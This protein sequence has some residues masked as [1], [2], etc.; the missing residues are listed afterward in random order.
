MEPIRKTVALT[1]TQNCNLACTYCYE[2]YKSKQEMPYELAVD[3]IDQYLNSSS[4]SYDECV[5]DF[6]GGEPFLNFPLIKRICEYVWSRKWKKPYLFS[7]TTNGTMIHGEIQDWLY[8]NSRRFHVGLSLDGTKKMHDLN[9]S[10]SFSKIDLPFFKNTW[11]SSSVKM[12][13]SKETLPDLAEGTIYIHGLGFEIHNN[14]AYGI[15]W[16]DPNNL[17]ILSCELKKLIQ[18]YLENP[19]I[20]PCSL[21]D[22]K[23]EYH[24]YT[25]KKWCG[26]GTHMVIFD[27]DGKNY[28][29]HAF[30][31]LSIGLE[32]SESSRSFDFSAIQ[33][34]ID[35]KCGGCILYN[36]CPTC[37]GSNF[38]ETGS[39]AIRNQQHCNLTKIRALACSY[40]EAKKMLTGIYLSNADKDEHLMIDSIIKI[41]NEIS[42]ASC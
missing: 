15:D 31:P 3:I 29:C 42:I 5:I 23:I 18:Y 13:I 30:L 37:Y 38:N 34:L 20:K 14:P 25:E 36:I 28:P 27:V 4:S 7:T 40:F 8:R 11:P 16:T 10:N 12:T 9:R 1:V 41:Q 33:N 22:M 32:K 21:L 6:F 24:G 35:P 19:N 2:G 17:Q 26:T 39:V